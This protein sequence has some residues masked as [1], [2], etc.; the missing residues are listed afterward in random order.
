MCWPRGFPGGAGQGQLEDE[1]HTPLTLSGSQPEVE[2]GCSTVP[3][4]AL[5]PMSYTLPLELEVGPV[6]QELCIFRVP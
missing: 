1:V 3:L 5:E 2:V 6:G 4:V